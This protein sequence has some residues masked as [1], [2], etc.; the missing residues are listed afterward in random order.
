MSGNTKT[1]SRW[2][3]GVGGSGKPTLCLFLLAGCGIYAWPAGQEP[4]LTPLNQ[5]S[6]NLFDGLDEADPAMAARRMRAL[7][8][9]RQKSMVADTDRLLQL[10][11][12]L[13]ADIEKGNPG[14]LTVVQLR[15]LSE[16]EKLARNVRQKMSLSFAAVPAYN[17]HLPQ[18]FP[19]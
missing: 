19:Q 4:V 8:L 2:R 7:N 17:P 11:K 13:Q 9:E 3:A 5:Q 15:E 14:A 16:I 10:V 1:R 18:H 12:A 6:R